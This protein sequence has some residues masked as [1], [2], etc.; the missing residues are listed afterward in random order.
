MKLKNVMKILEKKIK[1]FNPVYG[2]LRLRKDEPKIVYPNTNLA[3]KVLMWNNRISFSKGIK[4]T[5]NYYKK[6]FL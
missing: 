1:N 3:K 2:K 6:S 5:I 4:K